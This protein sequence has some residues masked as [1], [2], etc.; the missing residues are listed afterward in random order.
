VLENEVNSVNDNPIV[1]HIGEM[2]ITVEIFNGDY[3]SLEMDKLKIVVA[4]IC[5]LAKDSELS[6]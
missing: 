5:M 4:K 3:V 2:S 1:D 6:V